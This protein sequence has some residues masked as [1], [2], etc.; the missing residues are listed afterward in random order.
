[1]P[2]GYYLLIREMLLLIR[3]DLKIRA[4]KKGHFFKTPEEMGVSHE[5]HSIYDR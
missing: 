5:S 1:M 4:K 3:S 2:Q